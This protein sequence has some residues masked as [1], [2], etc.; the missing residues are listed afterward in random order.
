[1]QTTRAI[2]V[3]VAL[4]FRGLACH[5][6]AESGKEMT[7]AHIYDPRSGRSRACTGSPRREKN[8]SMWGTNNMPTDSGAIICTFT[9]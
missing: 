9:I 5:D 1:M 8:G 4:S 6:T 2:A 3:L 7:V